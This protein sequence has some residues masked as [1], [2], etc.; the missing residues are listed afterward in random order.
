MYREKM[1]SISKISNG[2]LLE[3]RVPYKKKEEDYEEK[4][5]SMG[6]SY[7]E[8]EIYAKD[9]ADIAK[10]IE[11]LMPMLD[12]DFEGESDFEAAFKMADAK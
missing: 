8:K 1:I 9:A 10:K 11:V 7:G 12:M 6:M 2:L 4:C 5:C 3:V